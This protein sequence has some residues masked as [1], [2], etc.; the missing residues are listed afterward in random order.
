MYSY[1]ATKPLE[2][3]FETTLTKG[4]ITFVGTMLIVEV[5]NSNVLFLK[6]AHQ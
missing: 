5:S 6:W 2:T 3:A 1:S 4:I